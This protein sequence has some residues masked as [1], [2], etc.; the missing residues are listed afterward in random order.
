MNNKILLLIV[1]MVMTLSCNNKTNLYPLSEGA[2]EKWYSTVTEIE[3]SLMDLYKPEFFLRVERDDNDDVSYRS[4][5]TTLTNSTLGGESS[6]PNKLWTNSYKAIA[7]ANKILESL[8]KESIISSLTATKLD[9]YR[10]EALFIRAYQYGN[11]ATHFGDIVYTEK[12]MSIQEAMTADK[13][14]KDIIMENVYRDLDIAAESLPEKYGATS[15]IRAT[16]GMAYA[17]KARIAIRNSNFAISAKASKDCMD[18]GIYKLHSNFAD[19]FMPGT[20]NSKECVHVIPRSHEFGSKLSTQYVLPRTHSGYAADIPSWD[21][22]CAF[23][24]SDGLP[25]DES[26]LYDPCN[27]FEN[28]DP[29]M[30]ATMI[31]VGRDTVVNF[32]GIDYDPNPYSVKV[33]NH[34]SDKMVKNTDSKGGNIYASYTGLILRKG[35]D[36]NAKLNSLTIDSDNIFLRYADV[37]LMYA[38]SKIELNEIDQTVLDAIN[39]VRARAYDVTKDQVNAYP[40][41][42]TTDQSALRTTIRFERRMEF[43]DEY[44]RY[45]DLIRWKIAEKALNKERYGLLDLEGLKK[46][47]DK[48]LWFF[49]GIPEIDKDGIADFKAFENA[50]TAKVL[51]IKSFPVRQYLW[52]IPSKEIMIN[53]NLAPNNPGY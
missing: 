49:P 4:N 2:A 53:P 28:R 9:Q 41:I 1:T 5:L 38:E 50:G 46:L 15:I 37:L 20:K 47:V 40:S 22:A 14:S 39:M 30:S 27:P 17:Y 43:A 23:L 11:M 12:I 29:R 24:C 21:L 18:L 19:L 44:L 35:I 48:G 45:Y 16:K 26:P 3:M 8:Q 25:I 52:P 10:A 36:E 34:N 32:L 13:I 51:A 31:S 42:T 7:R 33:Y 6:Q